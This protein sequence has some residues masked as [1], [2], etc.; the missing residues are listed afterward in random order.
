MV[1]L[2]NGQLKTLPIPSKNNLP[3][4][5]CI[6]IATAFHQIKQHVKR[7]SKTILEIFRE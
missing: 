1:P 3:I 2:G 4:N 7:D 5:K 6:K